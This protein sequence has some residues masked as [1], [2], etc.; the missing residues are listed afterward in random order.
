[1]HILILT[2]LYFKNKS[3]FYQKV[4]QFLAH[5][6]VSYIKYLEIHVTQKDEASYLD[7]S[8]REKLI[9][10]EDFEEMMLGV[11]PP[12]LKE[13]SQPQAQLELV[14]VCLSQDKLPICVLET[15]DKF[16]EIDTLT[17]V[18]D[19]Y[20]GLKLEY[21]FA[22]KKYNFFVPPA[23]QLMARGYSIRDLKHPVLY[24]II[25]G[26]V[27]FALFIYFFL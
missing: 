20:E 2:A 14:F 3:L 27:L 24:E 9:K 16:Q 19:G 26:V 21:S 4:V 17:V 15:G 22:S 6:N 1:M 8:F 23:S 7:R 10:L 18:G 25:I 13:S 5:R 11:L 12:I